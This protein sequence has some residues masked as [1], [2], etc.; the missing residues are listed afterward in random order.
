MNTTYKTY[1]TLTHKNEKPEKANK[2]SFDDNRSVKVHLT[3]NRMRHCRY[4]KHDEQRVGITSKEFSDEDI[5]LI[6]NGDDDLYPDNGDDDSLM[7]THPHSLGNLEYVDDHIDDTPWS[8]MYL[9]WDLDFELGKIASPKSAACHKS[10]TAPRGALKPRAIQS[11][12]LARPK[13]VKSPDV[14][15]DEDVNR[16][17]LDSA[18]KSRRW[19]DIDEDDEDDL[20]S[21]LNSVLNMTARDKAYKEEEADVRFWDYFC[22]WHNEESTRSSSSDS[23]GSDDLSV[24]SA[25]TVETDKD[26]VANKDDE[27]PRVRLPTLLTRAK[28]TAEMTTPE[29]IVAAPLEEK[30]QPGPPEME[31]ETFEHWPEKEPHRSAKGSLMSP[32]RNWRATM[33]PIVELPEDEVLVPP[34]L[35]LCECSIENNGFQNSVNDQPSTYSTIEIFDGRTVAIKGKVWADCLDDEADLDELALSW[36]LFREP[37]VDDRLKEKP[38]IR[39]SKE[40]QG[41]TKAKG[42]GKSKEKSKNRRNKRR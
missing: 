10:T 2:V 38:E 14:T 31:D 13:L 11:R 24:L 40:P 3:A 27:K 28:L 6:E 12:V 17:G 41:K 20:S 18:F 30:R 34:T 42:K 35:D 15:L 9:V 22:E 1:W 7:T 19:S 21:I 39:P 37:K 5:T 8:F 36:G 32:G 26:L 16:V 29:V 4:K 33:T 23:T 25:Q